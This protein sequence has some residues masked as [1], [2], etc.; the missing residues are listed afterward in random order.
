VD[1]FI[2]YAAQDANVAKALFECLQSD[3]ISTFLA[4]ASV[5][6][7]DQWAQVIQHTACRSAV[8]VLLDSEFSRKSAWVQQEAGTGLASGSIILPVSL[9]GRR[10][11]LPGWLA[12]IQALEA[13]SGPNLQSQLET[14]VNE[15]RRHVRSTAT[16]GTYRALRDA[17]VADFV[18]QTLA[19]DQFDGDTDKDGA[20]SRQYDRYLN[21]YWGTQPVRADVSRGAS[22]TATGLTAE[23]LAAFSRAKGNDAAGVAHRAL[24]RAE[25]FA[26]SSQHPTEGGFGRR[27]ISLPS[28]GPP[29]LELDIRH[30][31]WGVR[32]LLAIDPTA[33]QTFVEPALE[34]LSWHASRRGEHD[35]LCWTMAPLLALLNDERALAISSWGGNRSLLLPEVEHDVERDFSGRHHAWVNGEPGKPEWVGTDNALYVLYALSRTAIQSARIRDHARLAIRHLASRLRPAGHGQA[36][37]PFFT[38]RPEVGP[39]AQFLEIIVMGHYGAENL[40]PA[41]RIQEMYRFVQ[42]SL[43]DTQTMPVTFPWHLGSALVVPELRGRSL[44]IE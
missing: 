21:I 41:K 22:L 32:T 20:W 15:V 8:L 12:G 31:C 18:L 34:W 40:I 38:D 36:G 44:A 10:E 5:V 37:L 30:T 29:K 2:S 3:G 6:P 14:V 9:D 4:E 11:L 24:G 19:H 43:A 7:G 33:F 35:R 26:L 16:A 25:Q 39:T 13:K 42:N 1:C 17:T 27:S 23:R 28:R